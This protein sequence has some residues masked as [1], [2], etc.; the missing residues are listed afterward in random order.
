[1]GKVILKKAVERREGYL[2]YVD[3]KGNI[4]EAKLKRGGT[5]KKRSRNQKMPNGQELKRTEW[6]EVVEDLKIRIHN[7]EVALELFKAQLKEAEAH[8]RQ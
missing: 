1:M 4:C 8:A 6:S 7:A 5:K 2:Y 3:G